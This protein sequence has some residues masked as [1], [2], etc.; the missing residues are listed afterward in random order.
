MSFG[1]ERTTSADVTS[2]VVSG[3]IGIAVG[4]DAHSRWSGDDGCCYSE[5]ANCLAMMRRMIDD[6]IATA[7]R[8]ANRT[9]MRSISHSIRTRTNT[10][11][12]T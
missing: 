6:V 1:S 3:V 4:A 10:H 7:R 5:T 12:I 9:V 2:N 8:P 11:L